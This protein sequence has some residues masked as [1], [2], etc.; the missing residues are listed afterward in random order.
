MQQKQNVPV[1]RNDL[2]PALAGAL[3]VLAGTVAYAQETAPWARECSKELID[4]MIALA[5]VYGF[6][7]VSELHELLASRASAERIRPVADLAFADVPLS[8]LLVMV[9]RT[10]LY[11]VPQGPDPSATV[12]RDVL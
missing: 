3:L 2:V 10:R 11:A 5:E 7:Q 4:A 6:A 1:T 9:R 12:F 8:R